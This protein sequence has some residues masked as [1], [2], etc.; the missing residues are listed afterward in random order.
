M[1]V[2][3]NTTNCKSAFCHLAIC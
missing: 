3:W 1:N 2:T